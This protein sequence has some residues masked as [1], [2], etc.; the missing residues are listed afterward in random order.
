MDRGVNLAVRAGSEDH[1]LVRAVICTPPLRAPKRP[2]AQARWPFAD[3]QVPEKK[4]AFQAALRTTLNETRVVVRDGEG[5]LVAEIETT[6]VAQLF[7]VGWALSFE[8]FAA[9]NVG[10]AGA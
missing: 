7:P 8:G 3:M 9:P 4:K 5:R 10:V 2:P 6:L 1:S